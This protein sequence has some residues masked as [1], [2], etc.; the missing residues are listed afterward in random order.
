MKITTARREVGIESFPLPWA[1]SQVKWE[2]EKV[3]RKAGRQG[4]KSADPAKLEHLGSW[5]W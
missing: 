4:A 5:I 2:M 1:V 3:G